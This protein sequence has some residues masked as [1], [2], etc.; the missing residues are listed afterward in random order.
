MSG[1]FSRRWTSRPVSEASELEQHSGDDPEG[2]SRSDENETPTQR[3]SVPRLS[4]VKRRRSV[5]MLTPLHYQHG[6]QYP[7]IVWLHSAGC[8]ER[9]IEQVL[10]H[11]ST[12][13]Y[14]G[15]GVRATIATDVR[16]CGFDWPSGRDAAAKASEVV[17]DAID[18]AMEEYSI[19][20]ERIVLAG[21]GT[22]ATL[23]CKVGLLQSDRI[24]G[25]VRMGG[26]FPD[27]SGVFKNFKR[28]RERRMPML[29]QQAIN[30][31]DDDPQMLQRDIT[32]AQCIRAQVEI[33]QYRGDEVMNTVALKDIDRWC[34]DK[35]IAP[36]PTEACVGEAS[37]DGSEF[38]MVDFSAN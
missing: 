17:L 3:S 24:A 30:G 8:N 9:Q 33:R 28:L 4:N 5:Q 26:R 32:A 10:P 16:G 6:Y 20:P 27:A 34:F 36:K 1:S 37:L 7:L 29:W 14:V 2:D 31:V 13:N 19:H 15:L 22:G 38:T 23:A 18:Q 21:Y 25:V 11:V 12:R 35:I